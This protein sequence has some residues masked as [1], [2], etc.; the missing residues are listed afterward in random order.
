MRIDGTNRP[1]RSL[2]RSTRARRLSLS[3]RAHCTHFIAE[4]HSVLAPIALLRSCRSGGENR[5]AGEHRASKRRRVTIGPLLLS[6]RRDYRDYRDSAAGEI[7]SR[8][9]P[10]VLFARAVSFTGIARPSSRR[11]N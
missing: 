2:A 4:S 7:T 6:T 10:P 8:D 5:E 9:N 11:R 1:S 3:L